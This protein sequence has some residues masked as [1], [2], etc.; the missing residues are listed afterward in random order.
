MQLSTRITIVD[1]E[2]Y[3]NANDLI[4]SFAADIEEIKAVADSMRK[5]PG[6]VNTADALTQYVSNC[7]KSLIVFISKAEEDHLPTMDPFG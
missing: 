7:R 1:S 3:M 2:V 4:V 6:E 5:K